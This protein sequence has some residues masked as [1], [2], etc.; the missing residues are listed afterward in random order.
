MGHKPP[1]VGMIVLAEQQVLRIRDCS[2]KL[3]MATDRQFMR[4]YMRTLRWPLPPVH[5]MNIQ[6]MF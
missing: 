6:L 2:Q 5:A 3:C 1:G 4:H